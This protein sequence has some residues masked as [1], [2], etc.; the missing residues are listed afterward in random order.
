MALLLHRLGHLAA[1]AKTVIALSLVLMIMVFRS[2]LLP[3]I[4]TLGFIGSFAGA[5]GA[6]VAVFQWGRLG[7]L[8]PFGDPGPV[9]TFMPVIAIGVLFGLAMDTGSSPPRGYGRPTSR[10]RT[11]GSR[12]AR[13]CARDVRSSSRPR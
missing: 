9:L 3:V 10:V 13:A 1:R 8:F 4:A 12:F 5:M 6:V 7:E 2:L 11:P